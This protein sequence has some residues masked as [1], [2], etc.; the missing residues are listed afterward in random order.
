MKDSVFDYEAVNVE[1]ETV[2]L[3][4][5]ADKPLLIINTASL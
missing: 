5:Y 4:R 2:P 3:S 1:G